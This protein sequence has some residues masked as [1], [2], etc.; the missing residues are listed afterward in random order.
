MGGGE[1][2]AEPVREALC[3]GWIDSVKKRLDEDRYAF[4]FTPRRASSKWSPSNKR[5]VAELQAAGRMMPVGQALVDAAK[6][7]G[8]WDR[9][10]SADLPT[11]PPPELLALLAEH[12][13]AR[14]TFEALPPSH[15]RHYARLALRNGL[16]W[17]GSWL[18]DQIRAT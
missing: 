3:W 7:D 9:Q 14:Q 16:Q 4:K 8:S 17:P 10:M 1:S 6:A 13:A 12:D 18:C 15:R 2:T 5:R 11:T